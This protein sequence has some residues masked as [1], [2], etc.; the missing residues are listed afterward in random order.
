MQV[1]FEARCAGGVRKHDHVY[2]N[3]TEY[4]VIEVSFGGS[5]GK[6]LIVAQHCNGEKIEMLLKGT[7]MIHACTQNGPKKNSH[8]RLER[9]KHS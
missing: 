2:I 6:A 9:S 1:L 3:N 5:S 7:D 8:H 4:T